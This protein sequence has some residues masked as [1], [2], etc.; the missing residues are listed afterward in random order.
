MKSNRPVGPVKPPPRI[1]SAALS[2]EHL[3]AL[4]AFERWQR[5]SPHAH[6]LTSP[7]GRIANATESDQPSK[8]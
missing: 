1:P 6:A 8:N 4:A 3:T 2:T 7:D 5:E